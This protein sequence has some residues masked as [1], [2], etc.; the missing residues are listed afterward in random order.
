MPDTTKPG[1]FTT[2]SEMINGVKIA[3]TIVATDD[4][5]TTE[6]KPKYELTNKTRVYGKP[7]QIVEAQG[8]INSTCYVCEDC[9][10]T[11]GCS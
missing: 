10:E 7:A 5:P 11:T 1:E 9:G 8:C 2:I 3:N 4:Y 6:P